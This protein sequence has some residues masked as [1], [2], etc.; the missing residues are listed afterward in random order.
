MRTAIDGLFVGDTLSARRI[1]SFL[2]TVPGLLSM[3]VA[4]PTCFMSFNHV[5]RRCY[6]HGVISFQ[7]RWVILEEIVY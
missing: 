3:T 1:T 7:R 6:R 2:M 4:I 5:V